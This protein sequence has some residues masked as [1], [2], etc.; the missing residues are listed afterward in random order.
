MEWA[1]HAGTAREITDLGRPDAGIGLPASDSAD[2]TQAE[3]RRAIEELFGRVTI[4]R[5]YFGNEFCERLIP[6]ARLL[7]EVSSAV[8]IVV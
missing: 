3:A 7:A 4:R 2:P 8:I 5:I 1:L 6:S